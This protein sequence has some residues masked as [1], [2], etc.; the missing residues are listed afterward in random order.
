MMKKLFLAVLLMMAGFMVS[1]QTYSVSVSGTVE[2]ID[3]GNPIKGQMV[4]INT[5]SISGD[6]YYFNMVVTDENGYFEDNFDVP[7]GVSGDLFVSTYGCDNEMLTRQVTFSENNNDF[8]FTFQTCENGGGGDECQAMFYYYPTDNPL[9]IQFMDESSGNPDS[10]EWD[11]GGGGTSDEQN[12]S[13]TFEKEGEYMVSLTIINDST[14]CTSTFEMPVWVGDSIWFPDSCVAMFYAYPDESD[15]MTFV[16]NDMSIGYDGNPPDNWSWDF[17]DG[18]TSDAQNPVHTYAEEGNYQVCLTISTDDGDCENTYCEYIDVIDWDNGCEAGFYYF[19]AQDSTNDE[20][21]AIQFVDI[22]MGDPSTWN[23]EFGDG[24]TSTE[25][26]PVHVYSE[27][28]YYQVCLTIANPA[29]SCE[30]TYCEEIYVTNDSIYD[31]YSWFEYE[32]ND[33]TVDFEGYLNKDNDNAIFTWDFGDGN[34][35]S[36]QSVS[37]TYAEDG[38]YPVFM[39]VND[40][41]NGCYS[42]YTEVLWIGD[43]ITFEVDGTVYLADSNSMYADDGTV[44]LMTFDTIGENLVNVAQTNIEEN[45]YYHFEGVPLESCIYFVQADLSENSAYYGD[46]VPTYHISALHWTDAWPVFPFFDNEP[47]DIYMIPVEED[48]ASGNG[49]INGLVTYED[50]RAVMPGVEILLFDTDNNPLTYDLTNDDGQFDFS[51]LPYGTYIVYTEIVGIETT[52][53]TVTLT[54]DNPD[55]NIN[56]VVKNG[57]ALLGVDEPQSA[58]IEKVG[59]AYPNPAHEQIAVDI[60]MKK[61]SK[62]NITLVNSY[63]Q[64]LMDETKQTNPGINKIKLNTSDLPKGIYFVKIQA[65]DGVVYVQ[66][67]IK[68]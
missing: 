21:Y 16:F 62:L 20:Q 43:D 65:G 46:Y 39:E 67:L 44:Y 66:K 6:F 12:P 11:F 17:G 52:P 42:A 23:W 47:A 19:P 7:S 28:N 38:I 58:Y 41:A 33:L 29:D 54:A 22:S 15:Y 31:C 9:T 35:A 14:D 45:G 32:I 53:I 8:S 55:E 24:G 50:G 60:N 49:M 40:S 64:R 68:Y 26:N 18:T 48:N 57:E 2:D 4:F 63:G 3:S 59:K 5:D 30:D 34:T 13:H 10:W 61:S 25:Q 1:G 36:G 37:H 56:I 51:Q 27:E